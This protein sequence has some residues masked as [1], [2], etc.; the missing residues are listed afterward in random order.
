MRPTV[1]IVAEWAV[2]GKRQGTEDDYGVLRCNKGHFSDADFRD[3]MTRW[4]PGT[5]ASLPEVTISYVNG[6]GD[7]AYVGMAIQCWSD[8]QDG[9]GRPIAVTRYACVPYT[10]LACGPVSYE[11]LARAFDQDPGTDAASARAPLVLDVPAFDHG[12]IASRVDRTHM[13]AAALLLTDRQVCIVGADALPMIERLRHLDTVAAL[14]PYG[15]RTRLT[16]STWTDSSAAH[17]IRLAF[18]K[19]P[20]D[21]AHAVTWGAGDDIGV[22]GGD[23]A[24]RYFELL[25]QRSPAEL[26]DRLARTTEPLTFKTPSEA[27]ALLDDSGRTL[28]AGGSPAPAHTVEEDLHLC[29]GLLAERRT[30][31]LSVVVGR[32]GRS[33]QLREPAGEEPERYREIIETRLL[34]AAT[35]NL[36]DDMAV[37]FLQ[38][39]LTL[40]YG[41]RLTVESYERIMRAGGRNPSLVRAM[42]PRLQAAEPGVAVRLALHLD[43]TQQAR[44]LGQVQT[45]DLV[46]EAAREP[47]HPA[48]VLR[49]HQELVSRGAGTE[50]PE[51]APALGRHA[52]LADAIAAAHPDD[53]EA[54]IRRL[55]QLLVAAYG[56]S[57]DQSHVEEILACVM[58]PP[59]ARLVTAAMDQYGDAAE[60]A[61]REAVLGRAGLGGTKPWHELGQAY[62]PEAEAPVDGQ[63][64]RWFRKTGF[65]L[66]N[67]DAE[68]LA[69]DSPVPDVEPPSPL[70]P[71]LGKILLWAVGIVMAGTLAYLAAFHG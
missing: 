11:D 12:D 17:R 60:D 45:P 68:L 13:A 9:F 20:R 50:D 14:L 5:L 47:F 4:T 36:T 70:I 37:E 46:A 31:E 1:K 52:Y 21:E 23:I 53:P 26:V 16:A 8:E 35:T 62:A 51:I 19:H 39:L 49:V 41:R 61:L 15:L 42:W 33:A 44:L 28:V 30:G 69:E 32:L 57:L 40:G 18:A 55:R 29:A 64:T 27:L 22:P 25:L 65:R 67:R 24:R 56:A 3:I 10:D 7:V 34:P 48:L 43:R 66:R 63:T 58:R 38:V 71:P 2:W 54:Q 6:P 59:R